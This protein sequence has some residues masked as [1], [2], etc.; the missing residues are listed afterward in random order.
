[1]K[2]EAMSSLAIVPGITFGRLTVIAQ[3]AA[4]PNKRGRRWL[5]ECKCGAIKDVRSDSLKN[6]SIQSC[7]CLQRDRT[8]KHGHYRGNRPTP[9]YAAWQSMKQRC[10]DPN[11]NNFTDYGARGIAVCER[12]LHSFEDFLSDMGRRPSA[13]HSL[14]RKDN[15]GNYEPSNCVWATRSEQSRNR[16]TARILHYQG[17]SQC[18]YA[19][20]DELGIKP[21]TVSSRLERGWTDAEALSAGRYAQVKRLRTAPGFDVTP[22]VSKLYFSAKPKGK[23]GKGAPV[24]EGEDDD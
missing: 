14:E 6:G 21:T 19:W 7:G 2:E 4:S 5:C 10:C 15:S 1:L 23:G 11:C 3:A 13:E 8:T 24:V 16:R 12:W 22:T 18:L 17:R 9:E 20:A